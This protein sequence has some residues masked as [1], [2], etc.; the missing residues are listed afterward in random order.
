MVNIN[1]TIKAGIGKYSG[2]DKEYKKSLNKTMTNI[3]E[4]KLHRWETYN[5]I[6]DE[7]IKNGM[8]NLFEEFK[9]R[10]TDGENPNDIILN[11]LSRVENTDGFLWLMKKRI[12]EFKNEDFHEKLL[13]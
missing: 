7:L 6:M 4:D 9:Y 12:K 8:V 3:S 1:F 10:F 5:L 2:L 13:N 11:I